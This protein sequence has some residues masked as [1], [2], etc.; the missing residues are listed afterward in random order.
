MAYFVSSLLFLLPAL[1]LGQCLQ[2]VDLSYVNAVEAGG[3]VYRDTE[4]NRVDPFAY[5]AERGAEMVR[6]RLWHTPEN[7]ESACG[8]P[9]TS[10]GL[11]DMLRA[12]RRADSAGMKINLAV[13]YGD[14]FVDPG[15][16]RR[17]AAWDGLDQ[18]ILLD[19]IYGY[20]YR[21]LDS[22]YAQGTPPAILAVGNETDNGFVDASV[23]T[24]GFEWAVDGPKFQAGI[25]AVAAFNEARGTTIRSA[26]HMTE[27]YVRYGAEALRDAGVTGFD[28]FGVS[29]YP[30]FNPETTVEAIGVLV[31]HLVESYGKEVMIFETGFSWNNTAGAD[32]YNNF[33]GG[34]GNVVDYPA[35][36]QGQLDF[37]V[38]LTQTVCENGGMGVFYW[39]PAWV[40]STLCDAWGQGSSYENATFFDFQREN[41]A[42]PAFEF[43]SYET[44]ATHAPLGA[45][46]IRV[47]ANPTSDDRIYIESN[48]P[49]AS[50]QLLTVNGRL[51]MENSDKEGRLHLE[52]PVD[53]LPDGIYFLRMQLR[54]GRTV[55]RRVSIK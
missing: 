46:A 4:G 54:D 38:D 17:P 44:V 12:A 27:R 7:N 22:M 51:V 45:D 2:G 49:I 21:V 39:E 16:Q 32:D 6:L 11:A 25:D 20:T 8:A 33:L 40:T 42:L 3:G 28:I 53:G 35:T 31:K 55:N 1:L 26:I 52:V 29:Y 24:N 10:G 18:A 19:S 15:K 48:E 34:N 41:R 5:F 23:P 36:P 43:L 13:H 37:L 9:I 50:Y 14:Y 47:Y 30:F